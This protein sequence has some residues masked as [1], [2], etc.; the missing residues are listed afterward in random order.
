MP[1]W[2][3]R[4]EYT[5]ARFGGDLAGGLVAALIALPYG[6]ALAVMMGLPP[7]LGV[8]TSVITAPFCALFGRNAVLIGGTSSV[9]IPFIA[10]AVR[11]Q[12]ISGSAKVCLSAAIVMMIFSLLRLGRHVSRVPHSVLAGFSCGI[13]AMM[14][15]SQLK[16]MF[17]LPAPPSGW[18]E[19]MLGQLLQ[20]IQNLT[21]A[22]PVPTVLGLVVIIGA[23]LMVF[24]LPRGPAPLFGV[25]AA[26]LLAKTFGWH[27]KEV[28]ELTIQVP[29]FAGFRWVPSDIWT[30]L[31]EALGLAFVSSVNTLITSRVVMHFRGRHKHKKHDADLE[32]GAYGIANLVAG[33]FGAPTSVGIPARSLAVV[34]CGGST[35]ISNLAHAVFLLSFLTLGAPFISRIPLAALAGVTAW[36]GARL[37]D[38]GTWR[39]LPKMRRV[40]AAAFVTTAF[41]VLLVNAIAAVGLGCA[42]YLVRHVWRRFSPAA[43][44]EG[45]G[46]EPVESRHAQDERWN[47][48]VGEDG[49]VDAVVATRKP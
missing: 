27:E 23:T 46:R 16:T 5:I 36:T 49:K 22:Q 19:S 18:K 25:L 42:C 32:L 21:G 24:L 31:P 10:N 1:T 44:S 9:T 39:R 2:K 28:G 47:C 29:P 40:D 26:I 13:G 17:A 8:F 30:V 20:V 37:L 35:R 34:Q 48:N 3:F 4:G 11:E 15:I 45:S 41:S 14:V 7:I 6:L 43:V 33:T 38:W 12:G